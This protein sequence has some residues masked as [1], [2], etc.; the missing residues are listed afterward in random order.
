MANWI[1]PQDQ[2]A[3]A[4]AETPTPTKLSYKFIMPHELEKPV[5]SVQ[6]NEQKVLSE[7]PAAQRFAVGLGERL[8]RAGRGVK[9]KAGMVANVLGAESKWPEETA[10]ANIE[11]APFR[12]A[13]SKDPYASAGGIGA[14]MALGMAGPGIS[15]PRLAASGAL[16]E[17]LGNT[18]SEPTWGNLAMEAGKG[19]AFGGIG[20]ALTSKGLS[21]IARARNAMRGEFALP[22]H[23]KRF[24]IF[25]QY[26]VPGSLGDI[27][28]NPFI[29]SIENTAQHIPFTG[30]K[31]FLEQQAKKVIDT[32]SD[33]PNIVAGPIASATKEDLGK[34]LADSIKTKYAQSKAEARSLYDAVGQ[35]VKQVGAPPIQTT[36]LS[37]AAKALLDKYPSAFSKLTDD[38]KTVEALQTI[39]AG[40][41]PRAS[42]ILGPTGLPIQ[43]TPKLSFDDL[44]E[45]DSDLGALIR[46]GRTLTAKGEYNS[47]TFGQLADLQK[48]LRKDV[49]AWSQQVGDPAIS[50]GIAEANKYFKQNVMPFRKNKTIRQVLQNDQFDTDALPGL[51]FRPDS[52]TRTEQALSFLTLEGVQA[53]RHYAVDQAKNKAMSDVLSADYSPARFLKA[54]ELGETG[55]KLF[56]PEELGK[57]HDIRDL[58]KSSGRASTYAFDPSTGNRLLTLAPFTNFKLPLLAKLFSVT[59]QAEK[60]VRYMLANPR[61]YTGK[62]PLGMAA[63]DLIRKSGVGAGTGT[64][65]TD[66]LE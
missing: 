52:P 3:E 22:E 54:S 56:T 28:Q 64:F 50:T 14:E 57:L 44:R 66:E 65:V 15:V 32:I 45:L 63:E 26:G 43:K 29:Q 35:R 1:M 33:A 53:G 59:T 2:N 18:L 11:E 7:M 38:P 16:L 58:V 24:S 19:A 61:A 21:A 9:Q 48:A 30:R 60:P 13:I 47:K 12:E 6:S 46:Q 36:E 40:T 42:K 27:T 55:P 20:G 37:T 5:E 62:S 10:K 34:T 23:A 31:D 25:K 39:A 8:Q 49:D 41:S 4:A 51:L 17:G